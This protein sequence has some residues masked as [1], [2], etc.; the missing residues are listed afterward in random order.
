MPVLVYVFVHV[1]EQ[2]QIMYR[3]HDMELYRLGLPLSSVLERAPSD[4]PLPGKRVGNW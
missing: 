4:L 2:I 1:C 3:L